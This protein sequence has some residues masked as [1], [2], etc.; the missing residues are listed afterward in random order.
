MELGLFI[1][2]SPESGSNVIIDQQKLSTY[3]REQILMVQPAKYLILSAVN[4][5]N[6]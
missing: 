3:G 1:T 4:Q 6:P 2:S 5:E